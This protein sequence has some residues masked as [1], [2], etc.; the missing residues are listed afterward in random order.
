MPRLIFKT[1]IKLGKLLGIISFCIICH[2]LAPIV[3]NSVIFDTSVSKYPLSKE[4]V[5]TIMQIKIPMVTMALVPA[6]IQIIISGPSAIFGKLFKITRY[7]SSTL[8]VKG[9]IYKSKASK[10]PNTVLIAKAQRVSD[11]VTHMWFQIVPPVNSVFNC[12]TMREGE[13]YIKASKTP[14]LV[15]SSH[16][17]IN[18]IKTPQRP[19]EIPMR[20]LRNFVKY[21]LCA[22]EYVGLTVFFFILQFLPNF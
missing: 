3:F 15:H 8:R 11:S 6:P 12:D 4:M 9:N 14:M 1:A 5:V 16:R 7:G 2:L 20:V 13:L 18:K 17:P 19:T 21:F 22:G 10:A